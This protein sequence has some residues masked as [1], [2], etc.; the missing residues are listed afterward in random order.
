MEPG[1]ALGIAAQIAVALAGFAGV[2]V[3]FRRESVHEWSPVD[4]FRLRLL[5]ANSILPL[6]LCVIALLLLSVEP[7][8]AGV[9]RWCS[10]VALV[11]F[12]VFA[13]TINS[14]SRRL[15]LHRLQGA[16]A[17]FIFYSFT[18]LGWGA[19]LLQLFNVVLLGAFWPFFTGIVLQ[20][21][22]AMLQFARMILSS[23]E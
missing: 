2:V 5:L 17:N 20:L 22:A 6:G 8:L 23:P 16:S 1:E 21:V 12:L 14:S 7:T 13:I 15:G 19:V 4:R 3:V 11:V 10:G 18:V 9:W